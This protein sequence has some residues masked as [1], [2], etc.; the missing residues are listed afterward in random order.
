MRSSDSRNRNIVFLGQPQDAAAVDSLLSEH[1]LNLQL[2]EDADDIIDKVNHDHVGAVILDETNRHDVA[3]LVRRVRNQSNVPVV[4]IHGSSDLCDLTDRV[5]FLEVGAD[6][7]F[8]WLPPR[9]M[10][11][12]VHAAWRRASEYAGDEPNGGDDIVF[13][14]LRISPAKFEVIAHGHKIP[15]ALKEFEALLYLAENANRVV[16]TDELLRQVWGY[17][18]GVRTRTHSVHIGRIRAKIEEDPRNPTIIQTV[19]CLGYKFVSP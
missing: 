2:V 11:A 18:E 12:R 7:V 14:H 8:P 13:G 4:V 3:D 5:A 1:D 6:Q 16:R 10:A 9:E 15:L 17:P 19:P